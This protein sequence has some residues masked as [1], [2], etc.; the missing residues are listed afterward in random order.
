MKNKNKKQNHQLSLFE[1]DKGFLMSTK[2]DLNMYKNS[3]KNIFEK[4]V[5][6]PLWPYQ[7]FK[8]Y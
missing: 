8:N 4:K 5:S 3:V 1:P 2:D 6:Q 7:K